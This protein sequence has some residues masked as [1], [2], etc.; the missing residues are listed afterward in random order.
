[1]QHGGQFNNIDVPACRARLATSAPGVLTETTA[2][3]G[4]ALM[5]ARRAA[6]RGGT[7]C[8]PASGRTDVRPL[9]G[10]DAQRDP[11]HLAW[12]ASAS[13]SRGA[14]GFGMKVAYH[15]RSRLPAA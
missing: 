7:G 5:M 3:F 12:A 13:I 6:R 14:L 15:N 2:D 9:R 1:V 4:F 11:R 10:G 8:V